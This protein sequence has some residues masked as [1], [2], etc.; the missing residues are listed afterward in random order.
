MQA[1]LAGAIIGLVR[2][3]ASED[4]SSWLL[5]EGVELALA[6]ELARLWPAELPDLVVAA[7]GDEDFGSQGLGSRTATSLRNASTSGL[8]LVICE[9]VQIADFQSVSQFFRLAPGDL[10]RSAA[11]IDRLLRQA[12]DLSEHP[13][14]ASL[15][16]ALLDHDL[17]VQPPSKVVARYL[18]ALARG[19]DAMTALPLLGA[20]RD[21]SLVDPSAGRLVE[22]LNLAA[23]TTSPD[24]QQPKSLADIR[25]RAERK[26]AERQPPPADSTA[27]AGQVVE[28]LSGGGPT[29]LEMLT[30]AEAREILAEPPPAELSEEVARDLRA[31]AARGETSAEDYFGLADQLADT[32]PE[33][34]KHAARELLDFDQAESQAVFRMVTRRRLRALL[35]DR[36]IA[37]TSDAAE[38]IV[39]GVDQ[40]QSGLT[41]VEL[42]D[43]ELPDDAPEDEAEAKAVL[44]V[45]AL[46]LHI[47]PLL[48]RLRESG[49][50]V[51]GALAADLRGTLRAAL[52][53][54][55]LDAAA[56]RPVTIVMRGEERAHSVEFTWRPS[57]EDALA[58]C[59]AS[60]LSAGS[61]AL[62]LA[63]R[64]PLGLDEPRTLETTA[65]VCPP[66]L[67][68]LAERL[69]ETAGLILDRG[70]EPAPLRRWAEDW[71]AAVGRT[72]TSRDLAL[73]DSLTLA[74]AMRSSDGSVLLT[75]L[76]PLKSEWAAAR[77][78]GWIELLGRVY[79][80][81][82]A[83][84]ADGDDYE[85]P[86]VPAARGLAETTAANYPA[87]LW[88]SG[89]IKPLLPVSDGKF[90]SLFASGAPASP[91]S[92]PGLA[93]TGAVRKLLDLHPEARGHLRCAA[94]GAQAADLAAATVLSLLSSTRSG[95]Q[96]AEVF[97]IDGRPRDETLDAADRFSR[98]DDAGRLALRYVPS[99]D[100]AL[101]T[102]R[103][104]QSDAPGAHLAVVSGLTA[105]GHLLAIDPVEI[106]MPAA[107][108]D[109]LFTPRTW[110]R[111]DKDRR[112]LLAPPAVSAV[113]ARWLQ[114]G[115]AV[116]DDWPGAD[117][118]ILASEVRTDALGLRRELGQLHEMGLWVV[119]IDRYAGRDTLEAALEGDVAILHQEKRASGSSAQ[120][121]VISQKSGGAAD[122][123]IARS[124]KRSGLASEANAA[125][126]AEGLRR[127]ASRGHGILA[128]R[129]ATTATG[130]NEL[131]GHVAGFARLGM[132]STPWP[133]PPGCRILLVSLDEYT[134]WFN[135]RQ[136]AD[137]LALALSPAEHGVHAAMLEVK[138]MK[139]VGTGTR[140]AM[141]KAK[142]QL[143]QS[144]I[145]A[146]YAARPNRSLF[147]RLWLNRIV[148]A[149]IGVARENRFRLGADDLLALE[150]FRRGPGVLDFGGIGMVFSPQVAD[151]P[152]H[153]H[154][155]LMGDLVPIVLK[156]V[157]LSGE[158]LEEAA[159]AD[160]TALRTV[161]TGRPALVSSTKARRLPAAPGQPP[162]TGR[163]EGENGGPGGGVVLPVAPEPG[164][165]GGGAGA[166]EPA[167]DPEHQDEQ[168]AAAPIIPIL[169][170]DAVTSEPVDW[171]VVGDG[172][173]S[174]GH[175]EIYGTSGA[176]KTQFVQSLLAQL[177]A[178]GSHFGVCDFK[179]DY[180]APFPDRTGASFFD[181]WRD[182]LPYNPLS[183]E[184]PDRRALQSLVIELRDTVEGA[185][186]AYMKLGHR[187][188]S[189]L[190]T[191]LET[192]FE[193]ARQAGSV[194]TLADLHGVLDDDL[195]GAIGDL[196]GTELFRVGPPLGTAI[197]TD[198]VFAL[199]HIPGTGL[200]T[201]LA[202]GFILSSLYLKLLEM[203]QV[204][205]TVTYTLVIDE[206]HRVASF[207]S[208]GTMVRE[209]RSKGLAVV[210]ATQRPGDL[211]GE[212]GTNA[213]TKIYMRLPDAQAARQAARNLDPSDR[214]LANRIRTLPDG[215]A[216][217]ALA[218]ATP[219]RVRLR[220]FWRDDM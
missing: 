103:P 86:I 50:Q 7:S 186:R 113:G 159:R 160:S 52:E 109:V 171:R 187:Q 202:A 57:V 156:S 89:M 31:Y 71:A 58:L 91:G 39:R 173:L 196:T 119:T 38:A 73:L 144:L 25:I 62:T 80:G 14:A 34:R 165:G 44:A 209:L 83:Q 100:E 114:L 122:Q 87:Y 120:G 63:S 140:E 60:V 203:P 168:Q 20:F 35:R 78:D 69:Q 88:L 27:L 68:Q 96:R 29:L 142:E 217:V 15:R 134:G 4:G 180:G 11:G 82:V 101:A 72:Q 141:S 126:V 172:A 43:P 218:G 169:G 36:R 92:S 139:T 8:C 102:L 154:L 46:R 135:R 129:A 117:R 216:Y 107:D 192:V 212:A 137:L 79:S 132:H 66:A 133:L 147:S 176:G 28:A 184:S 145:E 85:A 214:E 148:E 81:E 175:I 166:P 157:S 155:P 127:A 2:G 188:L 41:S 54:L 199:N 207:H 17:E 138:A 37:T 30:F 152:M 104:R 162:S 32:D 208:V 59:Q 56:L 185:A 149:A 10:L 98:G 210:L 150:T 163:E 211:P 26:L 42:R 40:L 18:N 106:P 47:A 48:A 45:A 198:A 179:N 13:V 182:G 125:R 64:R 131:I 174:N 51:A 153:V 55:D 111:P 9:G 215:E 118:R 95:L 76:S 110:A 136:R 213:Q 12:P 143:R 53:I 197:D 195:R 99:L 123:A 170:W 190:Q 183:L 124:L 205:N 164:A 49:A 112:V 130:I 220:Q 158:L 21:E 181:L 193:S 178:M 191:A 204:A 84:Q 194:P 121:L 108:D 167:S 61:P 5:M 116:A 161:D 67:E 16:H 94:W 219:L 77:T 146:R 200:T 206:A 97:C 128:L 189:K 65:E 22:N 70:L 23:L 201:T 33:E 19:D 3:Q 1:R 151:A 105:E 90:V 24:L 93:F 74:G 6:R 177:K 115:T 75:H